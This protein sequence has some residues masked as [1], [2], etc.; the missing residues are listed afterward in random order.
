[1]LQIPSNIES[2]KR[3]Y[4][5]SSQ[6]KNW[7]LDLGLTCHMTPDISDFVQV[8]LVEMEKYLEVAAGNYTTSK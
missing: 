4:G 1:M 6:L 7:I 8:S 5:D 2:P 3:N